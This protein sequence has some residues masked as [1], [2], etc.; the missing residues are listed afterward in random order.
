VKLV[1]QIKLQPSLEDARILLQTLET[2]NA[3]ANR[4]SQLAWDT[5][6]FNKFAL[7][8]LFYAQLRSEFPTL[9]AQA[10]IRMIAKVAD[11]YKLDRKRQRL[12]SAHGGI[13][14][15]LRILSWNLAARNVSI[16]TIG[17]RRRLSYIGLGFQLELLRSQRGQSDLI[18]RDG[19]WYLLTTVEVSTTPGIDVKDYIGV[20]PGI[21]TIAQ[22]SDGTRF[23]GGHLNG[24]RIRN[25]RLRKKLQTKGTRSAKRLLRKRRVKERRFSRDVNH[26]ISKE[27]VSVAQRTERGIALEDLQG[28]RAR[29]R[30]HKKQR[31]RLHSWA[32]GQLQSFV[33]Y[34]AQLAGVPVVFVDPCNTSRTCPSCGCV[35]Q[36][37]RP[38]Q[39]EFRCVNCGYSDN[40]DATASEN[41]RR[42]AVNLPNVSDPLKIS[43]RRL[44]EDLSLQ[45]LVADSN[46]FSLVKR[47]SYALWEY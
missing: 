33:C 28:I 39:A 44:V 7:Q 36:R 35:D 43:A 19:S 29:V 3:A 24:L 8:R 32:F 11:A 37:N 27:L 23:A 10:V 14:Y 18:Y 30:A 20:D 9:A 6:E 34:K 31:S 21:V 13:A 26:T 47:I 38:S 45:R 25:R 17:G 41:I 12:F 22:T 16:W 1:V 2:L 42:A 40:A 4:L 5:G 46:C 15:D